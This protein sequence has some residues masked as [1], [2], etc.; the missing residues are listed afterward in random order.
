[1]IMYTQKETSAQMAN[2][3]GNIAVDPNLGNHID[4]SA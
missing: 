1:M 3:M 2:L 4:V